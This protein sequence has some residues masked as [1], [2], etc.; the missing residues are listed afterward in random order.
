MIYHGEVEGVAKIVVGDCIVILGKQG[1]HS[2]GDSFREIE[3][4][5]L[6][7]SE[8]L[9]GEVDQFLYLVLENWKIQCS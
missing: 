1:H 2:L 5:K 4:A 6:C 3:G 7:G 9:Y 8:H